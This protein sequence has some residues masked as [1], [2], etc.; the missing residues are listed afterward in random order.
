MD[1]ASSYH[2]CTVLKLTVFFTVSVAVIKGMEKY[3]FNFT[4]LTIGTIKSITVYKYI[5]MFNNPEPSIEY[6]VQDQE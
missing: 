2:G 4:T 3:D 5:K 1:N 6:V